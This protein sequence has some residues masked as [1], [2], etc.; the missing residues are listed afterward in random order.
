MWSSRYWSYCVLQS[1]NLEMKTLYIYIL[2]VVVSCREPIK[3]KILGEWYYIDEFKDTSL[4]F[5]FDNN[6]VFEPYNLDEY[7][8][9]NNYTYNDD[10]HKIIIYKSIKKSNRTDTII[11]VISH[12]DN[13]SITLES[14][15]GWIKSTYYRLKKQKEYEFT[16]I[17]LST[18]NIFINKVVDIKIYNDGTIYI[19]GYKNCTH[20]GCY[21]GKLDESQIE[22]LN[23]LISFRHINNY[24]KPKS[25]SNYLVYKLSLKLQSENSIDFEYLYYS[26]NAFNA[27]AYLIELENI[28]ELSKCIENVVFETRDY[29]RLKSDTSR[30]DYKKIY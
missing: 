29:T 23:R 5:S 3:N 11:K 1:N 25:N 6:Y 21:K 24:Y 28:I 18:Y 20:Q 13:D 10:Q 7:Y 14:E 19:Y 9:F 8:G 2:I 17:C 16:E 12:C 4:R 22:N 26:E 30:E 15:D 27:F